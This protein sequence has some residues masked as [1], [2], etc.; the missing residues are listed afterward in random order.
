MCS[1]FFP[2]VVTSKAKYS[3]T[4]IISIAKKSKRKEKNSYILLFS[5]LKILNYKSVRILLALSAKSESG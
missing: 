1:K 5:K 3:D 2:L 4:E